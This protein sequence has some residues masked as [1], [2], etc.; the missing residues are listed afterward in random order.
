M[1]QNH[2]INLR[3]FLLTGGIIYN[4]YIDDIE[5]SFDIVYFSHVIETL[6]DPLQ[7]LRTVYNMLPDDGVVGITIPV[8]GNMY[9]LFKGYSYTIQAPQTSILPT[10]KGIEILAYEAGFRIKH[11]SGECRRDYYTRSVLRKNEV[12]FDMG[13]KSSNNR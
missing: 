5:G 8:V 13:R 7:D 3:Y 10:K 4:K 6:D 1:G 12:P 2:L 11:Y 9:N